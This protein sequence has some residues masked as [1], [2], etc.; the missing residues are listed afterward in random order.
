[1]S[2]NEGYPYN[3]SVGELN[4]NA[5]TEDTVRICM[6]C[7]NAV[8]L[9]A[10]F[11]PHCGAAAERDGDDGPQMGCVYASPEVFENGGKE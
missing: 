6:S 4:G 8:P 9:Y 7:G 5:D 1:M 3:Y 11:C 10:R 2:K